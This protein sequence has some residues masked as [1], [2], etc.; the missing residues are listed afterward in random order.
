MHIHG[1]VMTATLAEVVGDADRVE[2]HLVVQGVGPG[3]PRRVVVPM[4]I[5]IA[6]PEIEPESVVGHAFDAE[7]REEG[8][9]RWVVDAISFASRRVLRPE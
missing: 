6:E 4:K 5:L 8:P 7:V 3:Q 2:M 9:K 1:I